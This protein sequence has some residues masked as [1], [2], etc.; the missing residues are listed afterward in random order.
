M[1]NLGHFVKLL[2]FRTLSDHNCLCHGVS[3]ALWG[4]QDKDFALRNAIYRTMEGNN[5]AAHYFRE[6]WMLESM[7][8]D[9]IN[10]GME[11]ERSMEE[12]DREW[13][14]ELD[15]ARDL[16]HSVTEIHVFILAHVIRRP[17]I[18]YSPRF[19]RD[20]DGH[21]LAPVYFGGV[22]LPVLLAPEERPSRC[23]VLLAYSRSHFTALLPLDNHPGQSMVAPLVDGDGEP[24]PISF[25]DHSLFNA[26]GPGWKSLL[27][28][29]LTLHGA[30]ANL[31]VVLTSDQLKTADKPL[32]KQC[33]KRAMVVGTLHKL[34]GPLFPVNETKD[35]TTRK[36]SCP[37]LPAVN[38]L[39]S[40]GPVMEKRSL[41]LSRSA[42]NL[43]LA[44]QRPAVVQARRNTVMDIPRSTM[45]TVP[46]VQSLLDKRST[47]PAPS[48]AMN[49]TSSHATTR[50]RSNGDVASTT[51]RCVA[52]LATTPRRLGEAPTPRSQ[53]SVLGSSHS[54]P[55]PAAHQS[56]RPVALATGLQQGLLA[57]STVTK[58]IMPRSL[59]FNPPKAP[60]Q[61]PMPRSKTQVLHRTA[62]P[63]SRPTVA[64]PLC[65]GASAPVRRSYQF[66]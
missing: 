29:Y 4:K 60:L 28:S 42:P 15:C 32:L 39:A 65:R 50:H 27:Q 46:K 40:G 37:E 10:F 13:Q 45:A 47:S 26:G 33:E 7:E 51:P 30:G 49:H 57:S 38:I 20:V 63:I 6:Q 43:N 66:S 17:I 34:R 21:E 9:R 19:C 8:R 53:P 36:V 61:T 59:S 31:G 58:P 18:V 62:L 56:T 41:P 22:Y 5:P 55:P 44:L 24:L 64:M 52:E 16:S 25:V 11:I 54:L 2:P 1:A 14:Q 12:W 35:R 23:P 3:L 48:S